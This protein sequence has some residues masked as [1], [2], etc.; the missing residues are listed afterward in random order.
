MIATEPIAIE[1]MTTHLDVPAETR[2]ATLEN[3]GEKGTQ[4]T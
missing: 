3:S 4:K 2:A 1:R